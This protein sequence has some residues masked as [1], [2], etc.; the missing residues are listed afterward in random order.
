M[1]YNTKTH[2][3]IIVW[4]AEGVEKRL[5][6]FLSWLGIGLIAVSGIFVARARQITIFPR[7]ASKL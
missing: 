4:E 1:I 3:K 2:A 6:S 5:P 7:R